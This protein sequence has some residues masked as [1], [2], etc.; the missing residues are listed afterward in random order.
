MP[1]HV[2]VFEGAH[3]RIRRYWDLPERSEE[4]PVRLDGRA[5]RRAVGAFRELLEESVRLRL[6]SDVPLG[7]FLSGGID[8]SAVAALLAREVNRP[9]ETFSVAFADRRFSELEYARQ[10]ARAVGANS[11][12]VVI[13]DNDFFGALPRLVWHED[14]PIAYPSSVPLHFVSALAREHVKVVLT[15]E[16]ADELLAGYGKY[17]RALL[18]WRAGGVYERLVPA[19]M[20]AAVAG[21]VVPHLPGRL[22]HYAQRSFLAMPRRP[23][24]MFLDNFAGM[25]LRVQRELLDASVHDGANPYGPSLEYFGQVNGA[26]GML[27]RLLY[28]DV[29]TYLVE[30]PDETGPDEHVDVDREPRAVPRSSAR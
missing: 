1:A 29:K 12:E 24:A 30:P 8:S 4:D 18:N 11:H 6:M 26:N 23:E 17:P 27:G 14:E 25:P 7:M 21:H 13:D 20:R 10:V 3:V 28:T 5:W 2:L 22:G 15:G 16:G 19:G 9:I